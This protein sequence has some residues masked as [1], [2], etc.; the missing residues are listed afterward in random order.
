[1]ENWMVHPGE[2]NKQDKAISRSRQPHSNAEKALH[3]ILKRWPQNSVRKFTSNGN[4]E[5]AI[6]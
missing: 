3:K 4:T 1:M 6:W 2:Q 5:A